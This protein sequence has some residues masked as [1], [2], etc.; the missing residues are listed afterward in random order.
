M[1]NCESL[2]R[3]AGRGPGRPFPKGQ[4]GNPAGR[5]PRAVPAEVL[6]VR[7][8]SIHEMVRAA[9]LAPVQIEI[10]DGIAEVSALEAAARAL[11]MQA[12]GGDRMALV[13]LT[14]LM[15]STKR[16][17][18]TDEGTT[19]MTPEVATAE[20][21]KRAWTAVLRTA[22]DRN[23]GLPVPVPHPDE[24]VIDRPA[25]V[26]GF[27]KGPP[28]ERL[29]FDTLIA[30]YR[31]LR[32]AMR[33]RLEELRLPADQRP[34]ATRD[35]YAVAATIDEIDQQIRKRHR[36][37]PLLPV[38][39]HVDMELTDA[40]DAYAERAQLFRD[41]YPE[42]EPN[43]QTAEA[44]VEA[45]SIAE[46]AP[47]PSEEPDEPA[48]SAEEATAYRDICTRA[49]D[50]ARGSYF[51][52]RA[53][54]PSPHLVIVDS[55]GVA[56]HG[57]LGPDE[58][59]TI[60]NLRPWPAR[61]RTIMTETEATIGRTDCPG[62]LVRLRDRRRFLREMCAVVEEGIADW[63]ARLSGG[64]GRDEP[65]APP[66]NAVNQAETPASPSSRRNAASTC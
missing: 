59:P 52:V 51:D 9:A 64:T 40:L 50:L 10:G 43:S 42:P 3:S 32:A 39:D 66:P 60:A 12:A 4:S 30:A 63:D 36:M 29:S 7:R 65:P 5:P 27:T 28:P 48:A 34:E 24:I 57:T 19:L 46:T 22:G 41:G 2:N 15:T 37:R 25:G 55:Q 17:A 53:P 38:I 45:P 14:R 11:A 13:T 26:V 8:G 23:V 54:R 18:G 56:C 1:E 21:Y 31:E 6:K 16:D 47:G 62:T 33:V 20:N 49:L 44:P 61:L 58:G 35:W